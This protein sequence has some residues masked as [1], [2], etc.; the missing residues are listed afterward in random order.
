MHSITSKELRQNLSKYLDRIEAGE[1]FEIIRRSRVVGRIEPSQHERSKFKLAA[2]I[3]DYLT[4]LN[5]SGVCLHLDESKT[6]KE[7]YHE[8]LGGDSKYSG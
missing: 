1:E 4:K 6:V 7:M 8:D 3:D 5:S 2:A